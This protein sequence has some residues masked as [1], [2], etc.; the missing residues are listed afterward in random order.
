M[1]RERRDLI[2]SL[3]AVAIIANATVGKHCSDGLHTVADDQR[4]AAVEGD[5]QAEYATCI[6]RNASVPEVHTQQVGVRG[7]NLL[8]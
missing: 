5:A 2:D 8:L 1:L 7:K 6:S 3:V 4:I